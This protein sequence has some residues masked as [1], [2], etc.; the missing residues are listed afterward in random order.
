[1]HTLR[2]PMRVGIYSTFCHF[3]TFV[4]GKDWKMRERNIEKRLVARVR[5][6]NGEAMKFVT[7]SYNGMPDRIVVFPGGK[8]SFVEC[9][10]PGEKPRPLQKYRISQL[11]KL[12]AKVYVI[13]SYEAIEKFIRSET[14][15]DD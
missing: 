4:T 13:D 11:E 8:I 14:G 10:A 7:N 1:V 15:G 6:Q 2:V 3:V 9:K 12:N 5:E